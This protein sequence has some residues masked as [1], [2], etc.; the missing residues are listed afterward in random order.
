MLAASESVTEMQMRFGF[1]V[2]FWS[3]RELFLRQIWVTTHKVL[4]LNISPFSQC[5]SHNKFNQARFAFLKGQLG[6]EAD[7]FFLSYSSVLFLLPPQMPVIWRTWT[8]ASCCVWL[9]WDLLWCG[10]RQIVFEDDVSQLRH[11]Q[12]IEAE[13]ADLN[14]GVAVCLTQT[15]FN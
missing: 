6:E 15:G 1:S 7:Y 9:W 3:S 12:C 10:R 5:L 2:G 4:F 13:V 8:E 11:S 14:A